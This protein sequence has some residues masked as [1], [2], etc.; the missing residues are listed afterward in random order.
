MAQFLWSQFPD[1]LQCYRV[2]LQHTAV[3]TQ[4]IFYTDGSRWIRHPV[5]APAAIVKYHQVAFAWQTLGDHVKMMLANDPA[6]FFKLRRSIKIRSDTPYDLAGFLIKDCKDVG[7]SAV[8][9]NIFRFEPHISL[10]IPF[11][12]SQVAHAVYMQVVAY[13]SV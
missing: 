8:K 2:K 1:H 9:N 4:G 10:V 7:L 11:I 3:I 6:H 5:S 13:T 12:R